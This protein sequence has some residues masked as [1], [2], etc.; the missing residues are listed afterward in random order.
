MWFIPQDRK[1]IAFI[2]YFLNKV[3]AAAHE[4]VNTLLLLQ[5]N[6]VISSSLLK[7]I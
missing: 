3:H 4:H 7:A 2:H 5:L 6:T 1:N